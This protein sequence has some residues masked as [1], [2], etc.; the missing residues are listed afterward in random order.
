MAN[1]H[2]CKLCC[3]F[4]T[5]GR[6]AVCRHILPVTRIEIG[7]VNRSNHLHARI[8]FRVNKMFCEY[9]TVLSP[10]VIVC[11]DKEPIACLS[12][13][14]PSIHSRSPKNER[15]FCAYF[16]GEVEL[17]IKCLHFG[18]VE[19]QRVP[20]GDIGVVIVVC[21]LK[22]LR[23]HPY[24][25][26]VWAHFTYAWHNNVVPIFGLSAIVFRQAGG[27]KMRVKFEAYALKSSVC[28]ASH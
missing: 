5:N 12:A 28:G 25:E 22:P 1:A 6:V 23:K 20:V 3:N 15:Y 21:R 8:M 27:K 26:V 11:R 13:R 18:R 4:V 16:F 24:T 7:F 2:A 14:H 19:I 10:L 17:F 9:G